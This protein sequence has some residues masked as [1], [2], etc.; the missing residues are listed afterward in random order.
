[1]ASLLRFVSFVSLSKITV[2]NPETCTSNK[3]TE[4]CDIDLEALKTVRE[5]SAPYSSVWPLPPK[6]TRGL[7]PLTGKRCKAVGGCGRTATLCIVVEMSSC[8]SL[9]ENW[10]TMVLA[11]DS[12]SQRFIGRNLVGTTG[13]PK[14]CHTIDQLYRQRIRTNRDCPRRLGAIFQSVSKLSRIAKMP[15][16]FL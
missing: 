2:Q 3:D 12:V 10:S 4:H 8:P 7:H 5:R 13:T 14:R 15:T 6:A 16:I 9:R 1:M 11:V